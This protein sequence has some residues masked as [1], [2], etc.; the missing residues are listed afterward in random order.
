MKRWIAL[1]LALLLAAW[2][3]LAAA[4]QAR[5]A[6]PGGTLNFRAEPTTRSKL[7]MRIPNRA[8]V[9]VVEH[10]NDEWTQITY[11]GKTGYVMTAYLDIIHLEEGKHVYPDPGNIVYV[12][13]K[14]DEDA[15]V[16]GERYASQS[17][18]VLEFGETWTKVRF[19]GYFG[20]VVGYVL[21]QRIESGRE[22]PVENVGYALE[23][24]GVMRSKQTGYY[25]PDKSSHEVV[26]LPKGTEV[27]VYYIDGSWC[28]VLAEIY[29]CY[30]PTSSVQLTG[31]QYVESTVSG[32]DNYVAVYYTATVPSLS[33]RLYPEP[34]ADREA[35][36]STT[37][38]LEKD[39]QVTVVRKAHVIEGE[40]WA[41]VLVNESTG[42]WTPASALKIGKE[43]TEYIYPVEVKLGAT[44]TVYA[45][46]DGATL[47]EEDSTLS[48]ALCQIPAGTE[49]RGTLTWSYVRTSYGGFEG[50]IPY[51]QVVKGFADVEGWDY[52]AHMNEP[53]PT[54][55]PTP[56]PTQAP[57]DESSFITAKAARSKADAAL[58]KAYKDFSTKNVTVDTE[59]VMTKRGIEGPLYELAYYRGG[60]YV[61]NALV[62][63]VTGEVVFTADYTDFARPG[64]ASTPKPKATAIPGEITASQARSR[65]DGFLRGQYGGF[66][67]VSYKVVNERFDSMPGYTGPV[68]RL[69]Y[70]D[71]ETDQF[72]Y[73]CIVGAKDG[74]VMYH[75]EVWDGK[76]TELD[77]STPTPKP[78]YE[79]REDIGESR[80]RAI[81][82]KHLN[83][84]YPDFAG[85]YSSVRCQY[86]ADDGTGGAFE[87]PY[88]QFDYFDAEGRLAYEIMVH[89]WTGKVLYAT[90]GLPG[91]GNG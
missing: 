16:I 67:D 42:G 15:R 28:R 5:V 48:K 79:S 77:Y 44:A 3:A 43:P 62:H 38:Q 27:V 65:A 89:A 21:T 23:E 45:G 7:L 68:F 85:G 11:K 29:T 6:T 58:K 55:S 18:E 32:V 46:P 61:Y 66:D 74:D 70:Y 88:Y 35:A 80:A 86:V 76:N 33:L 17:M 91:E 50:Q 71:K 75:T 41:Q 56:A 59:R 24:M 52:Q 78:Q 57:E 81:A 4:E 19:E 25:Y 53:A 13:E 1:A 63:A 84:K 9:T 90:G 87:K 54:A 51:S 31:E 8:K 12:R 20:D 72:A 10:T 39:Q 60:Q 49:L 2:C 30:V 69:N 37:V 40:A 47:Y 64:A 22:K 26:T 82:D 73:T 83:G 14:P 36:A 34:V